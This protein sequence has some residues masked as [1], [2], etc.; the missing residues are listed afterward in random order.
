MS[1]RLAEDTLFSHRFGAGPPFQ[2][3][4]EEELFLVDP[5]GRGI[6]R[7]T[8]AVLADRSPRLARGRVMGEMCDGVIELASPGCG[9][10]DDAIGALWALR[11][12][13]A[14]HGGVGLMGA[15]MHPAAAFGDV[16]YRGGDHYGA[17]A[18]DVGGLMRQSA[19]CGVHVHVGMPDA[20]TAATAVTGPRQRRPVR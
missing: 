9:S 20:E 2:V 11:R 10:A 8:D 19:V 5:T 12:D 15:G 7:C 4:V 16:A 3:G 13:V 14:G 17:V 1:L 6:R 18:A